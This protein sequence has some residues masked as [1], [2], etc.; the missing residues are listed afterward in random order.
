VSRHKTAELIERGAEILRS[1]HPMTVRQ[2]Y[3][4]L[5]SGHVLENSRSNYKAVVNA[6]R[7]ARREGLIPWEFIE[8]RLRRPRTV[9]MWSGLA[10]SAGAAARSYR[11]GIWATQP[12]VVEV[13]LEKD[14][15][16]GIFEDLLRTRLREQ[17][18]RPSVC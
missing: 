16:S 10:E 15:L 17:A 13:W 7:D 3:Y 2:V 8:D 9:S 6:Q 4:Q 14:A 12:I 18:A 5:I 11:R 1:H